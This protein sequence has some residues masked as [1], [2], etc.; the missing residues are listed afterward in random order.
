MILETL[1]PGHPRII[2]VESDM[3][4]S[5]GLIERDSRE[6]AVRDRLREDAA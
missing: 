4:R 5:K 1:R 3:D 6:R 2:A